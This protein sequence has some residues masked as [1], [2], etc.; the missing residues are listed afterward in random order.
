[1]GITW[2]AILSLW[3]VTPLKVAYQVSC[4]SAIYIM[5]YQSSKNT[6]IGNNGIIL[7]LGVMTAWGTAVNSHSVR[8]IESHCTRLRSSFLPKLERPVHCLFQEQPPSFTGFT[9]SYIG[10]RRSRATLRA[11]ETEILPAFHNTVITRTQDS[12][13]ISD[14]HLHSLKND[15]LD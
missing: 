7:S 14:F 15:V 12:A 3:A 1:M 10:L 8:D 9:L 4:M 2:S 13:F 5:V 11:E 6:V